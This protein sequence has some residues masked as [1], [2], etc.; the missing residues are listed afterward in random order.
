MHASPTLIGRLLGACI[1]A[2]LVAS[3]LSQRRER[4][5]TKLYLRDEELSSTNVEKLLTIYKRTY[6]SL[7]PVYDGKFLQSMLGMGVLTRQVVEELDE[8]GARS[9]C[10]QREVVTTLDGF[11]LHFFHSFRYPARHQAESWLNQWSSNHEDLTIGTW[12]VFTIPSVTLYSPWIMPFLRSFEAENIEHLRYYQVHESGRFLYSVLVSIPFSGLTIEII[13]DQDLASIETSDSESFLPLSPHMC[14][15]S[16]QMHQDP[17]ELRLMHARLGG[18]EANGFGLPDLLLIALGFPTT[19]PELFKTFFEDVFGSIGVYPVDKRITSLNCDVWVVELSNTIT[20]NGSVITN[21]VYMRAIANNYARPIGE[22]FT[23]ELFEGDVASAH[24]TNMKIPNTGWDAYVDMHP[25][26]HVNKVMAGIPRALEK[27]GYQYTMHPTCMQCF[28]GSI[29]ASGLSP[30]AV[31]IQGAF[32]KGDEIETLS[33]IDYCSPSS[34]GDTRNN[35]DE[36]I[37]DD[38]ATVG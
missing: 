19:K 14:P 17:Q 25:G 15:D 7:D 29:W 35:I 27:F 21:P 4:R 24:Q 1:L 11:Q 38:A 6:A 22:N 37:D 30:W 8:T 33:L 18:T 34:N 28:A 5:E 32:D 9:T 10:A 2:A 23:L 12:D 13:S 36:I 31:E 3:F 20:R 16:L 26:F